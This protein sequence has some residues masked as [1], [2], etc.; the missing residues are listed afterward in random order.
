MCCETKEAMPRINSC[1]CGCSSSFRQ[2]MSEKEKQECLEDY[3]KQLKNELTGVEE[4]IRELK[5]R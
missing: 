4:R 2:F 3:E 1:A 5:N